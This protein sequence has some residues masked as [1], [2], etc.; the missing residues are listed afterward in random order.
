MDIF[1]DS[2]KKSSCV[3]VVGEAQSLGPL[4]EQ[5]VHQCVVSWYR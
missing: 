3:V 5:E 2:D 4:S 1:G